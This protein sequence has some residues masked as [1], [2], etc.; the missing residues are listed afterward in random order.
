MRIRIHSPRSNDSFWI[1]A[2]GVHTCVGELCDMLHHV[3]GWPPVVRAA[4]QVLQALQ[5]H[6]VAHHQV[7]QI[8]N[9]TYVSDRLL[10]ICIN[11]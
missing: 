2:A 10:I 7:R 3:E 1:V 11:L 5:Q 6:V 4:G 9:K 8:L